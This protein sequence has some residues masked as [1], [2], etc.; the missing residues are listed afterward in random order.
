MKTKAFSAPGIRTAGESPTD[1]LPV[2]GSL[3]HIQSGSQHT[4]E[5]R[6]PS[7]KLSRLPVATKAHAFGL[8]SHIEVW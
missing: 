7:T 5:T 4:G 3:E 2:S 1:G 8:G 6:T